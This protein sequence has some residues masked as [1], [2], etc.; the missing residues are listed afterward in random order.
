MPQPRIVAYT[1]S[2]CSDCHRSK[3]L[4]AGR[5]VEFVEIDI[6]RV[7]GAEAAMRG[8]NGGSGKVPTILLGDEVLVEPTDRDL[9]AALDHLL[10]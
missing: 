3:R 9:E 4:L 1:T 8:L 5:G 6:E 2:W 10:V 7:A